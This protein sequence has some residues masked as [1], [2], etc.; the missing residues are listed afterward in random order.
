MKYTRNRSGVV[1]K[2]L[3]FPHSTQSSDRWASVLTC[4]WN[5]RFRNGH[6]GECM[7]PKKIEAAA[8]GPMAF[9][10]GYAIGPPCLA[11]GDRTYL[12]KETREEAKKGR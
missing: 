11:W 3:T 2:L 7:R 12:E 1:L 4:F 6:L 8:D 5:I 9:T 10:D